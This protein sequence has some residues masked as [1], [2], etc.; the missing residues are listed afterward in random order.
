MILSCNIAA[1]TAYPKASVFGIVAEGNCFV[2]IT[3]IAWVRYSDLLLVDRVLPCYTTPIPGS[4]GLL[5]FETVTR[6][7]IHWSAASVLPA[8]PSAAAA[9]YTVQ[10]PQWWKWYDGW[11]GCCFRR[12]LMLR[13]TDV[14][15]EQAS[16][17]VHLYKLCSP[18]V[19]AGKSGSR[20]T[21]LRCTR[22]LATNWIQCTVLLV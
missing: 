18:Y 9:P 3:A 10:S 1:P 8:A 22:M 14:N 7:G 2:F 17:V 12:L 21:A 11:S 20:R 13:T 4:L 6:Y 19:M 15:S 16:I 5:R